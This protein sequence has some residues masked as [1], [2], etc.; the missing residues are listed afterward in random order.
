MTGFEPCLWVLTERQIADQI[1]IA[2]I[3]GEESFRAIWLP[4]AMTT[5]PPE[6]E[7]KFVA[8]LC[9]THFKRSG[10]EVPHFGGIKGYLYLR[11][12]NQRWTFDITGNLIDRHGEEVA[13]GKYTLKLK[14]GS[15]ADISALF[16][17]HRNN[18]H[19]P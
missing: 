3:F 10:G 14:K 12:P 4:K 6:F 9:R 2:A 15:G 1:Y 19:H 16:R 5:L 13:R 18:G 17:R 8:L 11:R 7:L